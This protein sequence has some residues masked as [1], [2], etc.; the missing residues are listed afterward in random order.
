MTVVTWFR[1][2]TRVGPPESRP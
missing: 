1:H 2:C